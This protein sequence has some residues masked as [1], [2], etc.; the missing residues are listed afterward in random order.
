M[1]GSDA[2][3]LESASAHAA[4]SLANHMSRR[5]FL[6]RIGQ[7]AI[8]LSLGRFAFDAFNNPVLAH[9][10]CN[11]GACTGDCCSAAHSIGCDTLTGSNSCPNGS[12]LC[13][14]WTVNNSTCGSGIREWCDCCGGCG[15]PANCRCVTGTDGGSYPACCRHKFY[16]GGSGNSCDHIKCRRHRCVSQHHGGNL[17]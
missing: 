7:G 12:W 1:A 13:G 6:S 15:T 11:C 9:S 16:Q 17:C 10:T 5:S 14:C 3:R 4:R 2:T 8:V